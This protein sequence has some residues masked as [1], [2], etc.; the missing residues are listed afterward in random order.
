MASEVTAQATIEERQLLKSLNWWDG[1]VIALCNPG[2]LIASLGFTLATVGALGSVVL[3]GI[4][5]VVGLLQ[6]WIYS[7]TAAMFPDK[8]GGIALYAHEG[9]RKYFNLV[10]PISAFGYWIGWSV[11]LAIF[12]NL[13]GSLIVAEWFP[14]SATTVLF[15]SPFN[16][17]IY[18]ANIIGIGIVV[19]VWLFNIFG[20]KPSL[21]V[22]YVTGVLLMIPLAVFIIVPY[23][24]GDWLSSNVTFEDVGSA[25]A[26]AGFSLF[27][28]SMMW[29]FIMCWSAYGIEVCA[30]FAPEY[31]DTKRDTSLALRSSA[32]FSLAV[33]VLL[34]LGLGGV[35]GTVGDSGA[36]YVTA[37][38]AI[39]GDTVGSIAII[40]LLASLLL[41]M[42]SATADGGRA[43]Y[44]IA[45]DDMTI[46]WLYH[47]NKFHVPARGMTVDMF[48]NVGLILL[49]GTSNLA[50]LYMSNIGYVTAHVFAL[51]GFLLLRRD[52]P[53]WPRPIK[54]GPAWI[55]L[56]WL[57]AAF[58][59]F[60]V[61]F[62]VT[63]SDLA[64]YV[65]FY[66]F[67]GAPL[68]IGIGVLVASVVLFFYRRAVQDRKPITFRDLDVPTMP[69][70]DQMRMLRE[71]VMPD[72][73]S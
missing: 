13:I 38:K 46:K 15:N 37:F 7:E 41:S 12:G 70:E 1:F 34:P 39:V 51:T 53:D 72:R 25:G 18:P 55:G 52:R 57:L 24:T 60:L 5:A 40:S 73:S 59:L 68:W 6:N 35:V 63:Q 21:A 44:G 14:G 66:E 28:I 17:D 58:N 67:A 49:L 20:V 19:A 71:E 64:A 61:I 36:Y 16:V 26:S 29:L 8:P 33:Y 65:G 9:W 47:L 23:F 11:V 2:F 62:G 4:S 69:S 30:T 27:G 56:A 50:I 54:V 3:W 43:L 22:G 31:H 10:G 32:A 48:V 42:N 45:R